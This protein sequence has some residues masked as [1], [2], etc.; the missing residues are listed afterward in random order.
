[1]PLGARS[2]L[3]LTARSTVT[4]EM[5]GKASRG[6]GR[7]WKKSMRRAYA[8]EVCLSLKVQRVGRGRPQIEQATASGCKRWR[9][10]SSELCDG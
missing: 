3:L 8:R 5:M 9:D 10:G 7:F 1:M 6:R 4:D 2:F